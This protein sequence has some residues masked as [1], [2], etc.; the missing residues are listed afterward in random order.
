MEH[1]LEQTAKTRQILACFW[2]PE[3]NEQAAPTLKA[4]F[5]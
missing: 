5:H 4:T 3:P 1:Q 2:A